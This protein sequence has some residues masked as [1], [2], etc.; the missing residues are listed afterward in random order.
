MIGVSLLT[1]EARLSRARRELIEAE[2]AYRWALAM[3]ESLDRSV[4]AI[5]QS[6]KTSAV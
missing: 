3:Q 1:A 5:Q 4:A 2:A 6:T